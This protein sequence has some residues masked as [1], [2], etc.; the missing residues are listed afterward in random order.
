[1]WKSPPPARTW[2]PWT[3]WLPCVLAFLWSGFLIFSDVIVA[4]ASL[5]NDNAEPQT[6]WVYPA[7]LVSS[8]SEW[9]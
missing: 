1:M 6:S 7:G 9:A 4:L 3:I 8:L 2:R 5:L